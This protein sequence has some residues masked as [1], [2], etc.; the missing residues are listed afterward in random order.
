MAGDQFGD[1]SDLLNAKALSVQERR[2]IAL[3]DT[4]AG[5]W[6]NGWFLLPNPVYGPGVRGGFDEVF[7]ADKRWT[8]PGQGAK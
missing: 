5:L 1:F 2:R 8:D 7:P 6:G 4:F 3:G